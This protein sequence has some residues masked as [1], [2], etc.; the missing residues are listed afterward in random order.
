MKQIFVQIMQKIEAWLSFLLF[1]LYI[2]DAGDLTCH[3]PAKT[4]I[5]RLGYICNTYYN[6]RRK[7]PIEQISSIASATKETN[8][9]SLFSVDNKYYTVCGQWGA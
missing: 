7:G 5:R 4:L 1:L 9:E 2:C 8:V 3:K 6:Y